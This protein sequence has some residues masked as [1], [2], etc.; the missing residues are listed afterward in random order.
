M[1]VAVI[2]NPISGARGRRR[3][4]GCRRVELATRLLDEARLPGS[5]SV[6]EGP[7]Q[8]AA[9]ARKAVAGGATVVVAWGGDGTVNEVASALAFG[10]APLGIVPAGSGNGLARDL[11]LPT[12][13]LEALRVALEGPELTIDAG[14]LD[15]RLFFN[16]CGI[17][18]DGRVAARFDAGG[19]RRRG[20]LRYAAITLRELV[21]YRPL[22]YALRADGDVLRARA[23]LI[24]C[25]N[26]RQYGG[27]ALIAP[28]ARPDDGLLDLVVVEAR[29]PLAVL[30]QARRLFTGTLGAAPRVHMR[31]FRHLEVTGPMAVAAHVDG[32]PVP[33]GARL[34]VRVR[35]GAL[36]VRVPRQ[37]PAVT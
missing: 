2:V 18:F 36:R 29:S 34:E 28:R 22:E 33:A 6:T 12:R 31:R 13:P 20:L 35:P 27:N 25:A 30:W 17:G 1:R 14:E 32:E 9:H 21:R 37:P 11:G 10:D 15:G 8:A 23:L 24:A 4:H 19:S 26:G 7:G 3:D 5:V 16:L